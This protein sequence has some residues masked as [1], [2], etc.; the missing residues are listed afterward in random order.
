MTDTQ[1]DAPHD[2][3]P[4]NDQEQE[5]ADEQ[6]RKLLSAVERIVDD[7]QNL[8]A[9]VEEYERK[10]RRDPA[11][12]DRTW[13]K[14]VAEKIVSHYSTWS[15]V[16]GGATALPA[17][18]PG[19]GTL[20]ATVGGTLADMC[21]T[22]KFE[23]EMALC[24]THLYGWDIRDERERHL[25]Y[26][27]ASVSTHDAQSGGNFLA[28]LAR[29]EWEAIW[30]YAPRQISKHLLQ[31]MAKLAVVSASKSLVRA[32]PIIG[33]GVSAGVNKVLTARVGG[34]CI[35]ELARRRGMQADTM[36]AEV[37]DA[38]FKG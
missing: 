30:K 8:I 37:V 36:E 22:L 26:L 16:S 34:R 25:A 7:P 4:L 21:M 23:V 13:R 11:G 32:L 6:G 18:V 15:A 2:K 9:T 17:T 10:T 31:V 1:Q 28:D 20:I 35:D 5:K 33:I 24:L 14:E 38:N 19:I 27:L 29:V 12:T 3:N